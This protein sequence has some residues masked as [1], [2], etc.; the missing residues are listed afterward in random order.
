MGKGKIAV[1]TQAVKLA[2]ETAGLNRSAYIA[3]MLVED[4]YEVD[5]ITS[6]FQHWEK[7]HRNIVEPKFYELPYNV[8]FID[9][10]GYKT[11]I[12]ASRIFSQNIFAIN[13]RKYLER[14]G[15]EYDLIWC[16]IPPNN[17]AA[18]ASIFASDHDIPFIVDINDLWP[19]AMKMIAN[20]PVVSDF[21]FADFVRESAIS[22][23]N[24]S[25]AVG[26]SDEY[27]RQ[28][29]QEIPHLT[30]YVGSDLA[31]FDAGT[32]KHSDSISKEDNEL[33]VTYAGSLARS[34][35]IST[36]IFACE[37]ASPIIKEATGKTLH[38]YILGDGPNRAQLDNLGAE[39]N[40]P[41]TFTGYIDYGLM[42]AYLT[43]SDILI[44]SL[45]KN[46]PQSIVS[47]ISDYLSAGK[48]IINT[49]ESE[50]FKNK[51]IDDGFGI[52]VEPEN[53][54]DLTAAITLLAEDEKARK[55]MG[56]RGRKIAEEQFNR[57]VSY[58]KIVE[59]VNGLLEDR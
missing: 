52:N 7:A 26:T 10:P 18:T 59:L 35:D 36:L 33:W 8:I 4:G 38:L 51:C 55:K 41:I 48:P 53:V 57:R 37:L 20:V 45:S 50:E 11:N 31:D 21:I 15:T 13:L 23:A 6:T 14:F 44:N 42:A 19:E 46:A 34:Y 58:K 39:C 30:V 32:K 3:R 25:A 17:V 43:K 56:K 24:A 5:V 29:L 54:V 16:K 22:F 47:K 27:A 1:I 2:D 12:S 28:C 49:G 40:Y 9:E